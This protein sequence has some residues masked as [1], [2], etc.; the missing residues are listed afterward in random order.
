MWYVPACVVVNP[1][2]TYGT[3]VKGSLVGPEYFNWDV[4]LMRRIAFSK[5]VTGEFRLEFFN[6]LNHANFND[7]GTTAGSSSFGR[8]TGAMD[9]RIG[10][11]SLKVSF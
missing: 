4:S 10:Q 1:V 7:P 3:V 9:P 11:L 2:G 5:R 6:V 8:I